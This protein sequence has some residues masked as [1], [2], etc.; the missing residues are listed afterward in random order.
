MKGRIPLSAG[1]NPLSAGRRMGRVAKIPYF[2]PVMKKALCQTGYYVAAVALVAVILLSFDYRFGEALFVGT[3][4]LPGA[5]AARWL[6][7]KIAFTHRWEGIRDI[8]FV[9]AGLLVGEILLVIL[10]HCFIRRFRTGPHVLYV[11]DVA[12]ALLNPVFLALIL[13]VLVAG[14]IWLSR[15]LERK[16]PAGEQ[17][18]RFVSD[19]HEVS[20]RPSEIRYVESNDDEVWVHATEGRSYRNKT[21]ISQWE[22]LLGPGFLRIHRAYLVN[23]A[24][25]TEYTAE[26]V[27][28][29]DTTLP[30][31]RKYRERVRGLAGM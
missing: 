18:L 30:V 11:P 8:L 14:D 23:R 13:L 31:S 15:W 9:T 17:P 20:L 5:L 4:F 29:A 19:R 10:A 25:I 26:T 24:F 21:G 3:M 2:C 7:P 16:Y 28:L 6:Y 12:D 22:A 1:E 27:T